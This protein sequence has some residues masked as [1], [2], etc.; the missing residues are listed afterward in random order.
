[1]TTPGAPV[2]DYSDAIVAEYLRRLD[3]AAA[4]VLA[5]DRRTELVGEIADHITTAR[6]SG[7]TADEAG[8]RELLDRLGDPED[9]V[10]AARE[11]DPEAAPPPAYGGPY[12][13]PAPRYR[14]PGIGLEIAAVLL[15][16]IGSLIPFVGW[17]AGAILL[18]ASRR[19]RLGEKILATLVV[20]GGPFTV[21][22][23]GGLMGGQQCSTY[24]TTDSAG[25]SVQGPTTCNGFA[26]PPWLGI[27]LLLVALVGPF[28]IG[29]ILLRRASARAALEPG[30]PVYGPAGPAVWGGLEIAAVLLLSVGSFILPGVGPIAGLVCAWMSTQWTTTEKWVAT[31]LASLM[32]A[33]PLV[34]L[35]AFSV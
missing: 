1:M 26:F 25:N 27:P 10:A 9:I 11:S 20:P 4:A 15:L 18:W 17:L 34:G 33:I 19:F 22:I 23:V 2:T 13:P 30:V 14:K 35:I 21:L 24:S 31:A 8:V 28:V 3:H 12:A 7:Q 6:T 32:L 29:G 16:T 5:A